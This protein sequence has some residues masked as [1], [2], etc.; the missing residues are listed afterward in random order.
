MIKWLIDLEVDKIVEQGE[1][2][3][4][5][6]MGGLGHWVF[7]HFLVRAFGAYYS[8]TLGRQVM[9]QASWV[10]GGI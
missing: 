8:E 7:V 5:S 10:F 9:H 4:N 2:A 6:E 3:L 1:E